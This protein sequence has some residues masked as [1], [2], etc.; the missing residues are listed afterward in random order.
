M[1]AL[2][3]VSSESHPRKVMHIVVYLIRLNKQTESAAPLDYAASSGSWE[4]GITE[5]PGCHK[6]THAGGENSP[7]SC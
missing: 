4:R 2:E 7:T 6:Q 5:K 1:M 3:V